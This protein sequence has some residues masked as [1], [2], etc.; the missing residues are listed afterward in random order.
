MDYHATYIILC[1]RYGCPVLTEVTTLPDLE[2]DLRRVPVLDLSIP[3]AV[4]V[5]SPNVG[6]SSLV[7]AISTGTAVHFGA[8]YG[9]GAAQQYT[10]GR[11]ETDATVGRGAG[12]AGLPLHDQG[13]IHA[14]CRPT[15][16][17]SG[18]RY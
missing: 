10:S 1:T 17:L 14:P 2:K 8:W 12:S 15:R 4:L 5:G 9:F 16:S 6:K 13:H 7:R 11:A 18:V 3:S